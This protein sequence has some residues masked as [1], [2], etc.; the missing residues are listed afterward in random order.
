MPLTW[1]G[2]LFIKQINWTH[3]EQQLHINALEIKAAFFALQTFCQ[4]LRDQH[5]H[6]MIDNTIAFMYINNMGESHSAICNFL[7]RE[8]WFGPLTE[9][10]G[11]VLLTCQA[12]AM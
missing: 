3:N 2:V 1:V 11:L 5:V 8:I 9:I 10:Y 6:V 4:N 12:L 7:A